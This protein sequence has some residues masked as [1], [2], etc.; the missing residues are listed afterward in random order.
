MM[1]EALPTEP[2]PADTRD[3]LRAAY[4]HRQEA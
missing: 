2:P 3:E 4:R 1:S